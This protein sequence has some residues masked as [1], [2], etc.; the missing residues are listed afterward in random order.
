MMIEELIASGA[1]PNAKD[2]NGKTVKEI[3]PKRVD[4]ALAF[5]IEKTRRETEQKG[6]RSVIAVGPAA[7]A[8]NALNSAGKSKQTNKSTAAAAPNATLAPVFTASE[9]AASF[10]PAQARELV[11]RAI[12]SG[13]KLKEK[14]EKEAKMATKRAERIKA[15]K[16]EKARQEA[17]KAPAE[18][19]SQMRVEELDDADQIADADEEL[20]CIQRWRRNSK[21]RAN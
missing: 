9:A 7:A 11:E 4:F 21:R 13:I 12:A 5:Q 18:E 2:A 19:E 16:E 6:K 1:E 8:I 10:T 20:L 3:V 17:P 14:R 15:E